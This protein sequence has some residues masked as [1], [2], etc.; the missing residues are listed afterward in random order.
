MKRLEHDLHEDGSLLSHTQSEQNLKV[1]TAFLIMPRRAE[2]YL[3]RLLL[4][5]ML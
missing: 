4:I 5:V 2:L 1:G 3:A